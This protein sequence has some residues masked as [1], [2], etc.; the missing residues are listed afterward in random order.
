VYW[1]EPNVSVGGLFEKEFLGEKH[2]NKAYWTKKESMPY[3]KEN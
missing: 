3:F 1:D 2:E